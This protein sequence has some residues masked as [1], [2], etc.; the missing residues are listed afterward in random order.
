MYY[1]QWVFFNYIAQVVE[2]GEGN[3]RMLIRTTSLFKV[4]NE[5]SIYN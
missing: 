4:Y 3:K 2:V 5:L 1:V